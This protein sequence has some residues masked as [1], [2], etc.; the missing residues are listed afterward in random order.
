[1]SEFRI[2]RAE[3]LIHEEIS[4]MVITGKIKDP[5]VNRLISIT[6]VKIS[7]DLGYGKI[8]VSGFCSDKEVE[9]SVAALNHAVGFIQGLIGKKLKTR[10]TPR[11]KF[12][13]DDSLKEGFEIN[14]I[15]EDNLS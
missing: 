4:K 13:K 5:R 8:F 12:F 14:R 6:R 10:L 1:M 15:I 9:R 7:S 3:K 11:L 2:Q